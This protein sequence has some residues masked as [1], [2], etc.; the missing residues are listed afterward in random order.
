MSIRPSTRTQGQCSFHG[1]TKLRF[2]YICLRLLSSR[3][4]ICTERTKTQFA[5]VVNEGRLQRRDILAL[6]TISVLSAG[7]QTHPS[8]QPCRIRPHLYLI[9][10]YTWHNTV[11]SGRLSG[12]TPSHCQLNV[13]MRCL[14]AVAHSNVTVTVIT[15]AYVIM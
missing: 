8:R 9:V 11:R 2:H 1:K 15:W 7:W 12:E 10:R 6:I 3:L 13:I 5:A 4:S 14:I